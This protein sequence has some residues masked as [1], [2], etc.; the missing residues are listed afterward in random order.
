LIINQ[1]APFI[2][3]ELYRLEWLILRVI[4]C[5]EFPEDAKFVHSPVLYTSV[6]ASQ[7]S[8]HDLTKNSRQAHVKLLKKLHDLDVIT[9]IIQERP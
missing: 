4:L 6:G 2:L 1:V 8:G 5:G 9:A 7:L 3:A